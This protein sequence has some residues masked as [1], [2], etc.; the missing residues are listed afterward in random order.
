[1]REVQQQ[2]IMQQL[3]AGCF[4]HKRLLPADGRHINMLPNLATI[5]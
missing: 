4:N 3:P 1:V 5:A 2:G